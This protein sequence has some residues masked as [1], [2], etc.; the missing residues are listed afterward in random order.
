MRNK[1]KGTISSA[2]MTHVCIPPVSSILKVGLVDRH[3]HHVN[4]T[5]GYLTSDG[6]VVGVVKMESF[7]VAVSD[8]IRPLNSSKLFRKWLESHYGKAIAE[9]GGAY[10]L[11]HDMI[12]ECADVG[13]G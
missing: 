3:G 1:V 13:R 8:G 7:Y 9:V 6:E 11:L 4:V 5:R 2:L 10:L 12:C